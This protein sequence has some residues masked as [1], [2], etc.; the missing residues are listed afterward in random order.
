MSKG[1]NKMIFYKN[2]AKVEQNV[3]SSGFIMVSLLD[4]VTNKKIIINTGISNNNYSEFT[5]N[6]KIQLHEFIYNFDYTQENILDRFFDELEN[7]DLVALGQEKE[8]V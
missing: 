1:E 5:D 3:N 7:A 6:K 2:N 4:R 8:I